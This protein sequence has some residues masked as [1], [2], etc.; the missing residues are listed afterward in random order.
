MAEQKTSGANP[1][2]A[3]AVGILLPNSGSFPTQSDLASFV[4]LDQLGE[5][6]HKVRQNMLMANYRVAERALA[7]NP[8]LQARFGVDGAA[9]AQVAKLINEE[10]HWWAQKGLL[11]PHVLDS[12]TELGVTR[13]AG[14]PGISDDG[15]FVGNDEAAKTLSSLGSRLEALGTIDSMD[16]LRRVVGTAM[17]G[18]P[19]G[20]APGAAAPGN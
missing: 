5:K 13:V 15:F 17:R 8:A 1:I 20:A 9:V 16:S 14:I 3:M 2:G 6:S 4:V 12:V 19:T 7:S 18:M 11:F 10:S